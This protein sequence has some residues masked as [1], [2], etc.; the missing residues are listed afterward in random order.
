MEFRRRR[1]RPMR[2]FVTPAGVYWKVYEADVSASPGAEPTRALIAESDG[3]M[4]RFREFPSDWHTLSD[5]ELAR[6][7]A[8][9]IF[10][11]R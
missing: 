8:A 1:D 6:F 5:P 3:V 4:R 2:A 7:I 11:Q 10:R 9:P